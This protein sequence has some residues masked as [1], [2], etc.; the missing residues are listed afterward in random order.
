MHR[1][2][3][4]LGV[5]VLP[6]LGDVTVL[7]GLAIQLHR[8]EHALGVEVQVTGLLEQVA[9]RD[10]RGVDEGVAAGQMSLAGVLL[11]LQ[12]H[13]AAVRVEHR[14][15]GAHLVGEAEQVQ[16]RTQATVVALLSLLQHVLV[17]GEL[18]LGLPGGAVDALQ[19][20]VVLV[21]AP[22]RRRGAGNREGRDVAR[23]RHVRAAAQVVPLDLAGSRVYVG[24][25]GQ[26]TCADLHGLLGVRIDVA[27]VLD[28]LE[29]VRLGS[30]LGASLIVGAIGLA[31]E[32]L[33]G[34][35]D[36]LHLPLD[37]LQILGRE[38][39]RNVKVVVETAIDG[40]SDA[41]LGTRENALHSLGE[42]VRGG[43]ADHAAPLFR[44][45]RNR[46][47]L[48]VHLR[49]PGEVAEVTLRVLYN[50][51]GLGPLVRQLQW[52]H[53]RTGCLAS[54]NEELNGRLCGNGRVQENAPS[55][56]D[57]GGHI[58]GDSH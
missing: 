55:S 26:L 19:A 51:D 20:R 9:L 39:L 44:I 43:V 13:D 56:N 29:L 1:A 27:L 17:F 22:I 8:G 11:H 30:V 32:A 34:L 40:R 12:A 5:V 33:A 42:N 35:D 3:H 7:I 2:V 16:L 23:G 28:E 49:G 31:L 36:L 57:V 18:L 54:R 45:G 38:R 15:A 37:L 53:G 21:A 14:E 6:R 50:D 47:D 48:G 25:S 41:E 24:V 58:P 4:R 10:V 46:G 52:A